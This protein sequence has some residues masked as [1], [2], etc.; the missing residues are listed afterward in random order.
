MEKKLNPAE[1]V[2]QMSE[3]LDLPLDPEHYP[4]VVKNFATICCDRK[5]RYR[6]SPP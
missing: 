4:G 1:Y 5:T 6:I 2:E 3:V